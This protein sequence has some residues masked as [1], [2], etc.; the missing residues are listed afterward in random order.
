MKEDG[1]I[2]YEL[3][4]LASN[5]KKKVQILDSFISLLQKI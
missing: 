5:Q 2:V 3:S 1:N 4:C